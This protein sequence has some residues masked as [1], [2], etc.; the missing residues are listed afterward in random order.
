MH[1]PS[2]RNVQPDARVR[3]LDLTGDAL[4]AKAHD[5]IDAPVKLGRDDSTCELHA[6]ANVAERTFHAPCDALLLGQFA[7]HDRSS[8]GCWLPAMTTGRQLL[9][10]VPSALGTADDLWD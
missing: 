3:Y 7:T 8:C 9:G 10:R 5:K 1:S 6:C 2:L 4:I